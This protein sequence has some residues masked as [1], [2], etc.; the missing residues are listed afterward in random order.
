M[1][2]TRGTRTTRGTRAARDLT[3]LAQLH[4][5]A[6]HYTT[7]L[8][9]RVEP[10]LDTLRA[11]LAALGVDASTSGNIRSAL[12]ERT[13]ALAA[14]LLPPS[15]VLREGR[16]PVGLSV[17]SGT[18]M[19]VTSEDGHQ[20]QISPLGHELTRF[21][22][23]RHTLHAVRGARAEAVPLLIA[24]ERLTTPERQHWGFLAQLYSVLSRRSWGLGDLG[25]L[26]DM[27]AWAGGLGAD[28]VLLN[29]LYAYVPGP[30][31]DPSPY[32]PSSRRHVDPMNLRVDA[33][34]EYAALP[35]GNREHISQLTTLA[36][37]L[38]Q[39][40]L[41]GGLIDRQAVRELKLRALELVHRVTLSPARQEAYRGYVESEGSR[42]ADFALWSAL[43]E[44]HGPHWRSWPSGVRNPQGSGIDAARTALADRVEFHSRLAWLVDEQ[45]AEAQHAAT[46]AGMAIGLMHDLA[47]GV[48]PQGVDAWYFQRYLAEGMTVG[49][50]PDDFN[51]SGQDWG[52]PPWR[53]DTLAEAGYAPFAE[54]LGATLRRSDALRVDHIMGLFRLWWIPEG[55]AASEGTYVRYD[56]DA[57]L[58]VLMLEAH[59]AGSMVIGEDLGTVEPGVRE[60][61]AERGI[62][63]TS[64]LRFEYAGG[65]EERSGPLPAEQWRAD[66]LATLTTHDLPS[67]ATW[68]DGEHVSLRERLGLLTQPIAEERAGAAAERDSWLDELKR[69]HLLESD[70]DQRSEQDADRVPGREALAL[71]SFLSQTPAKL[72]G[73]WLP[74][75]V[76]DRRPQNLPGTSDEYPNWCLPV[77]GPDGQALALED[78]STHPGPRAV[79]EVYRD[80]RTIPTDPPG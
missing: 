20:Q 73:V 34:P 10:C 9:L 74:D 69:T 3:R 6:T 23:G 32:R 8:G 55:A 51:R 7:D 5:V 62:L 53:P 61:M 66:C 60:E 65:S 38:N 21:P 30:Q 59:R 37:K 13:Q 47:V 64:V 14:R 49:C 41:A 22:V 54:V 58:G 67:T 17:Q 50:P 72:I 57:L 71:H 42:L 4:G 44:K 70:P 15:V 33:L 46:A 28:F 2:L 76:G 40:V 35:P 11:V 75:T 63:G 48:D 68:L 26:S 56:H 45:L 12:A 19:W 27:V 16:P 25:D 36:G 77:A 29:P 80:L 31:T 18:E 79:A 24:P 39:D 1:S 43:A 78:I 52:L